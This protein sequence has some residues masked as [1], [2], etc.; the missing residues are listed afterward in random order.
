[1]LR[2]QHVTARLRDFYT[3]QILNA[4]D[5]RGT[6]YVYNADPWAPQQVQLYIG[7]SRT[8]PMGNG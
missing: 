5:L 1:M 3:A 6:W 2:R 7:T 8:N 4:G